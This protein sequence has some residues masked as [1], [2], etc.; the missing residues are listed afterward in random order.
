MPLINNRYRITDINSIR[1]FIT[2]S[3]YQISKRFRVIRAGGLKLY[4]RKPTK[5]FEVQIRIVTSYVIQGPNIT[6]I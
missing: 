2:K 1:N 4:D 3:W 6:R 5:K